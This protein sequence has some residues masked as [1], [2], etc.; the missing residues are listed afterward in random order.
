MSGRT[1]NTAFTLT[2]ALVVVAIVALLLSVGIPAAKKLSESMES[3]DGVRNVVNAALCNARAIAIKEQ[4]YAGVRFQFAADGRQYM[5]LV[6]Y[7]DNVGK[8]LGGA[9]NIGL[10]AV[11]RRKPNALPKSVGVMDLV[12]KKRY[13]WLVHSKVGV[14]ENQQQVGSDADLAPHVA[15]DIKV[16]DATTFTILFSPAG[17]LVH[18]TLRVS[19]DVK[20]GMALGSDVFFNTTADGA[21]LIDDDNAIP[22]GY[23]TEFSRKWFVIYNVEAF[24]NVS[25][26]ARWSGYLSTLER[27]FVNPHSGEIINR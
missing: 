14:Q 2:E 23:Q 25:P 1:K 22:D 15:G 7:D 19:Y 10:R 17:K 11:E 12:V 21:L 26:T 16:V 3:T 13:P 6:V 4:K 9:G 18:H 24:G 27:V 8:G 20:S 5:V